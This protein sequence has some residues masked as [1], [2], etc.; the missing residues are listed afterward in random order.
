MNE[1]MRRVYRANVRRMMRPEDRGSW[2]EVKGAYRAARASGRG[3]PP[4]VDEANIRAWSPVM[5]YSL[6]RAETFVRE[7]LEAGGYRRHAPAAAGFAREACLAAAGR[8]TCRVLVAY[9]YQDYEPI[10]QA[11]LVKERA[12]GAHLLFLHDCGHMMWHDRPDA[13]AEQVGA[14]LDGRPVAENA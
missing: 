5:F 9:G 6:E 1:D 4:E 14:F 10:V 8:L 3:V 2:Q 12:P 13:F 11:Y 7:Y